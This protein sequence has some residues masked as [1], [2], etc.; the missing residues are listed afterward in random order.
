MFAVRERERERSR[1]QVFRLPAEHHQVYR[2]SAEIRRAVLRSP[3][4][5]PMSSRK[6]TLYNITGIFY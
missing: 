2:A 5:E 1:F 4:N 6:R 3:R